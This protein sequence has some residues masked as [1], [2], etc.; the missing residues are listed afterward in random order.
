[1]I[2]SLAWLFVLAA[3][4]AHAPS[5]AP[6]RLPL[7]VDAAPPPQGRL[8]R[9][10]LPTLYALSLKVVPGEARFTGHVKISLQLTRAV[11]SFFLH[12]HGLTVTSVSLELASGLRLGAT[13]E[14]VDE[15]GV[16]RVHLAQV[17]PAGPAV[18][19]LDWIAPYG[20]RSEG[21]FA[22]EEA[23]DQ[24]AFTQFEALFAR[25]VFPCFDEPSFKTPFELDV[26]IPRSDTAISNTLPVETTPVA[27]DLTHVRFGRTL[28]LPTYLVMLAV[29]PL[30]VVAAPDLPPTPTRP[31][32]L[33]VR[34][35][36]A[37][38]K[39][40]H[41]AWAL[42]H[43]GAI[44]EALEKELGPFPYPK[45]DLVAVPG[46]AAGAMENAGA[47]T[48]REWLLLL[49]EAHLG[50]DQKRAFEAV[51]AHELAHQWFGDLVTLEW[52]DD[53]WLNE[54]FATWMEARVVEAIDPEAHAQLEALG[55]VHEA[56]TGDSLASARRVRQRIESHHD[57]DNAF[58]GITYEKGAGVIAMFERWLGH[59]KFAVGLRE[60]LRRYQQ[61]TAT[62]ADFLAVLSGAAGVDVAGPFSSF[63]DQPG[64]PRVAV[65]VACEGAPTATLSQRRSLPLG[66]TASAQ[67]TWQLPVCLRFAVKGASR[68]QCLLLT[69]E[70]Q[71]V[72]LAGGACPDWLLP[73]ADG[74]GYYRFALDEG[75]WKELAAARSQLSA[76][77]ELAVADSLRAAF[78]AG[79]LDAAGYYA[80]LAPLA[81]SEDRLV[82]EVPMQALREARE[83][84]VPLLAPRVEAYARRLFAKAA[85]RAQLS[86]AGPEET[87]ETQLRR[88]ALV[89][90]LL[91]V[92]RDPALRAEA[93][94]L[95]SQLLAAAARRPDA[96]T[97]K[98]DP[99]LAGPLM[100]VAIE[101]GW[102]PGSPAVAAAML[103]TGDPALRRRALEALGHGRGE[104]GAGARTLALTGQLV[105]GSEL[106]Y[107]LRPQFTQP[108]TRPD[109]WKWLMAH[110]DELVA[111]LPEEFVGYLPLY[112]S[113][114]CSEEAGAEVAAF[115]GPRIEKLSGGPRNLEAT[116]ETIH[117]CAARVARHRAGAAA[118]FEQAK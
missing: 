19:E 116:L 51:T 1:M 97:P 14:E 16:A 102:A 79:E 69:K 83:E 95:G 4:C 13:Y 99:T 107:L 96:P 82:A 5:P 28:P 113:G 29:G 86:A 110:Y 112:A 64:V 108:E 43:V 55:N 35:A 9:D 93:R 68:E 20:E 59:E 78:R 61:R 10:V 91:E 60:Y 37:R 56:M 111:K 92:A 76:R 63:L 105:R 109:A 71:T 31:R 84:L 33:P 54:A 77:E 115:F 90:F 57:V 39:G 70:E 50:A 15:N 17:A 88:A 24:Y 44:V 2:R 7:S 53:L 11:Q 85:A 58:D 101:E 6:A 34:A 106:R 38:G 22:V 73:N 42:A 100:G 36:A 80:A 65:R 3:G 47:V 52:W 25:R 30:D 48:F 89:T 23:G 117:L 21:L 104:A 103:E 26:T 32:P 45:L 12:G 74:A 66:S 41:L 18:L 49:D 40:P 46:F 114:F 87:D 94:F 81:S 98:V 62:A 75:G 8:P 72:P 67:G 27:G 118:F